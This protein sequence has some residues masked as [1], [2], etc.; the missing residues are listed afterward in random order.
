[1]PGQYIYHLFIFKQKIPKF[2]QDTLP[3]SITFPNLRK[4][5]VYYFFRSYYI[6]KSLKIDDVLVQTM[7]KM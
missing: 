6:S 4:L 7:R 3:Y 1:M 5:M 2:S